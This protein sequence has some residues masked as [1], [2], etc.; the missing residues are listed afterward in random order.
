MPRP[1]IHD[2]DGVLDAAE[3]IAARSGPAAVTIRAVAQSAG[4][5]NGA[6]YHSFGSRAELLGR[7][8]LRAA[9]RFLAVQTELVEKAEATA[10]LDGVDAIVAAAQAP[11][12]FTE[13]YPDSSRLLL[14]VSREQLLGE[15]LP[16]A[17]AAELA[18]ADKALV[19][20]MVRL[21]RRLWERGDRRAVEIVT[22]CVVDLPTAILLRRDR[23]TDPLALEQLRAAVRAVVAIGPPP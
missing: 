6:M 7:T 14:T 9:R 5:S 15:E 4:I 10:D 20:L 23:V 3:S 19:R 17:L 16:D 13:R 22:T 2:L 12:V 1:R 21:A 8:W 18:G 11:A